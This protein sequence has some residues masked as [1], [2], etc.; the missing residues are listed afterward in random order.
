VLRAMFLTKLKL[1]TGLL[2]AAGA[3][4]A[5]FAAGG[6]PHRTQAAGQADAG[7]GSQPKGPA[8][9]QPPTEGRGAADRAAGP[10]EDPVAERGAEPAKVRALLKERFAILQELVKVTKAAYQSGTA[11]FAEVARANK[12]L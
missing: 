10:R 6:L 3:L 5:A 7:K 9:A 11:S 8:E 2:L 4:G 1:V 12:Q